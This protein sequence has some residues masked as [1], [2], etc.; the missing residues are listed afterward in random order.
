MK[1]MREKTPEQR[2]KTTIKTQSKN[3]RELTAKHQHQSNTTRTREAKPE[4]S[5]RRSH[6][7]LWVQMGLH[8]KRE[9]PTNC[10]PILCVLGFTTH[11]VGNKT[12]RTRFLNTSQ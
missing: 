3:T 10:D 5:N 8:D 4:N 7:S 12:D 1:N 11:S 9:Q 2:R 6:H